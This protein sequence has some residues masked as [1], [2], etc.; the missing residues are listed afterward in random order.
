MTHVFSLPWLLPVR[1]LS[2]AEF[3][4]R[5]NT[6]WLR[7]KSYKLMEPYEPLPLLAK[8]CHVCHPVLLTVVNGVV[9]AGMYA[10]GT[11][12]TLLI[13]GQKTYL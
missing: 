5:I 4:N 7:Q 13:E 2:I 3:L 12:F 11:P 1:R 9:E 6:L 8:T 10:V